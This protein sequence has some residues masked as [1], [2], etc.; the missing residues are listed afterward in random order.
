MGGTMPDGTMAQHY[1]DLR[2]MTVRELEEM[3]D[4]LAPP[5]QVGLAFIR[6][7]IAYRDRQQIDRHMLQLTIVVAFFTIVAAAATVIALLR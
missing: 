5:V 4:E 1:K 2:A 6:E 3:Y 7:E